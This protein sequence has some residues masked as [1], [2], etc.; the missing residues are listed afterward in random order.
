MLTTGYLIDTNI[1]GYL[2]LIRSGQLSDAKVLCVANRVEAVQ[3]TGQFF[4][5]S[6]TIGEVHYGLK[7]APIKD[8]VL[9]AQV[10]AVLNSFPIVLD[11]DIHVARE[12]YAELRALLFRRFAPKDK[13]GRA[14]S[15]HVEDWFKLIPAKELGTT[16][17]DVWIAS[18]AICHNL[19]L[20]T[21]DNMR[22]IAEV[23]GDSL[24]IE[25]WTN[26][27]THV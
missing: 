24:I 23:S 12:C 7:A 13:R 21:N 22:H 20:V 15:R 26:N 17:N 11:I 1:L 4:I 19:T 25:N 16:E 27:I 9:Q 8:I 2:A 6:T 3:D 5:C 18:V 10:S 14:K